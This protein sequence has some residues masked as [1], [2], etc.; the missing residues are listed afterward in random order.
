MA[1][2]VSRK[3][4]PRSHRSSRNTDFRNVQHRLAN[5]IYPEVLLNQRVLESGCAKRRK[6]KPGRHETECLAQMAGIKKHHSIGA[7]VMILPHGA[8]EH[9]CH[10]K[11]SSRVSNEML[12]GAI[13]PCFLGRGVRADP[14][15]MV[16][17]R[18]IMVQSPT[19]RPL[20]RNGIRY[21]SPG[22]RAPP[23][24]L[25]FSSSFPNLRVYK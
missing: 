22:C 17:R 7:R 20:T 15:E 12:A 5:S 11:Q 16:S 8:G 24:G 18:L 25:V 2:R 14:L 10:Q 3:L 21:T 9:C 6:P 1:I 23:D 4:S 13:Q 19:L